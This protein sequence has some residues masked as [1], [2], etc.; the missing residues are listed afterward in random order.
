MKER[1][2]KFKKQVE[3][4]DEILKGC[5]D[6]LQLEIFK[7]RIL[8]PSIRQLNSFEKKTFNS[9]EIILFD[10][11][12]QILKQIKE[13]F[14]RIRNDKREKSQANQERPKPDYSFRNP[15]DPTGQSRINLLLEH[16]KR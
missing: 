5:D 9:E 11:I 12:E 1:L 15:L 2:E 3:K 16:Q 14:L 13:N 7:N 8:N 10:E 6:L 4:S